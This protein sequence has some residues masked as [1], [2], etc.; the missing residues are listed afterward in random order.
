[1]AAT[2]YHV[3][4]VYYEPQPRAL[5]TPLVRTDVVGFIGFDPRVTNGTTPST[6]TWLPASPPANPPDGHSFRVDVAGFQLMVGSVRGTVPATRD[7]VLSHNPTFIPIAGGSSIVYALVV[8]ESAGVFTLDVLAGAAAVSGSERA[9]DDPALKAAFGPTRWMRIA[10][11][12]VRRELDTVFVTACPAPALAITRCDDLRD[13]VLAF[14]A[15]PDDGTLLGPAVHAF[16]A[17]GGRRCWV[18]TLR[19]PGFED[20]RELR[21]VLDDMVG[22]PGSSQVE[23]T[24]LERLLLVPEVTIVDAPDLHALRVD[25]TVR[26]LPLPPSEREA[27]FLPCHLFPPPGTATTNDRT[28]AWTPVFESSPP[29]DGTAPPN[30]VFLTQ[31]RLLARCVSER[32]RVLLLLSVPRLPDGGSGPYVT[33]TDRDAAAWVL[34]FDYAVKQSKPGAPSLGDTD[35]VSC[36]ALYWPW[37]VYQ[38]RVDTPILEMPPAPYAAGIIARRDLSRGP[39]ISPANET[40]RQVV[41]LSAR[42]DDAVHGGLYDPDPDPAGFPVPAVN[43]LRAFPGY[44]VQL[45]GARTLST[46]TWLRF[47]SVRRTLTAIE[48]R[49]KAALV[50]LVFEPNR[51]ELWLQIIQSAFAVLL[52]IFESG[53]L[54]GSRPEEAFYVRCDG[55]NN[56]PDAVARGEL[57]VE[58]GVAVAAPAEFI[59]FRVGRREG[60]IEVL[61]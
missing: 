51:P 52:P 25:R 27:C 44:G 2:A 14:G 43:V 8:R 37:V 4:G 26:T 56:P 5:E 33:P 60:V 59:V 36:A 29:F 30:E 28:P 55:R 48:L 18:A 19:R 16:F 39:Q 24:G 50:E 17:N 34:Q 42:F 13:Y 47:V 35:D 54:R 23:A 3:P 21:N 53:A 61:E 41:A 1:M 15:P 11:V 31:A 49:M 22:R 32:W 10:D 6:L 7:F 57:L 58:V 45:W 38:E 46:E 20:R 40:L 12:V 9:P